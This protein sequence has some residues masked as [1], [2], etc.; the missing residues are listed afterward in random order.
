MGSVR[1]RYL[2]REN[3]Y[4]SHG[5]S[6]TVTVVGR[7]SCLYFIPYFIQNNDQKKT[8]KSGRSAITVGPSPARVLEMLEGNNQTQQLQYCTA[9]LMI[10]G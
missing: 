2:Q 9:N 6:T 3:Y 7:V 1:P 10:A 5:L 4:S 8:H